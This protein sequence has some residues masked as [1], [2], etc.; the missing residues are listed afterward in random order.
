[1]PKKPQSIIVER[2][3]QLVS[4]LQEL[5]SIMNT[6]LLLEHIVSTVVNL[7]KADAVWILFP[8]QPLPQRNHNAELQYF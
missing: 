8:D 2:Y 4:I 6:E 5:A 1:M 7:C 3:Q